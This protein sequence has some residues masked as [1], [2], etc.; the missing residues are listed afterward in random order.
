MQCCGYE[1]M[2]FWRNMPM[3]VTLMCGVLPP[4]GSRHFPT[5]L[6]INTYGLGPRGATRLSH[7][8]H[9]DQKIWHHFWFCLWAGNSRRGKHESKPQ[10]PRR[11]HFWINLKL[12]MHRT[13]KRVAN[14]T[15]FREGNPSSLYL[16]MFQQLCCYLDPSGAAKPEGCTT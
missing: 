14:S 8:H 12:K 4:T 15:R 3:V 1:G 16:I 11:Y 2:K 10:K 13:R 7:M 6:T 9:R 5:I